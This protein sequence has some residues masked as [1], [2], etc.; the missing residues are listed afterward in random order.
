[1]D[2]PFVDIPPKAIIPGIVAGIATY[3]VFH[4]F[5]YPDSGRIA[6]F[7]GLVVVGVIARCRPLWKAWRFWAVLFGIALLHLAI[8]ISI[9]WP[10]PHYPALILAPFAFVDYFV[11]IKLIEI[12]HHRVGLSSQN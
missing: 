2:E 11:I 12:A 8:I 1:M 6:G 4:Y 5:G 3:E 9:R 7:F 10:D